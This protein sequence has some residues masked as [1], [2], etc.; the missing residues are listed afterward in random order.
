[1]S[2]E[3]NIVYKSNW[4]DVVE[5]GE[6]KGIRTRLDSVLILPF[7]SD[8]RGLPIMLGVLNERNSFRSG[9]YALSIISGSPEDE[10]P[11]ILST[12]QRE[13]LEET[14]FDIKEEERW[15]FLGTLTGSKFVDSI[16]PC[17]AVDVTG[18]SP[19]KPKTD[20]SEQERLSKF[21]LIPANDVISIEDPFVSSLFLRIFKYVV[22]MDIYNREDSIFSRKKEINTEI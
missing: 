9:G 19:E 20:G 1:M 5:D 4:F 17:F 18:I 7:T 10:D 3:E 14:G 22:G 8:D 2:K 6:I 16:H 21:T 15:Y 13:L 12:A 11:N